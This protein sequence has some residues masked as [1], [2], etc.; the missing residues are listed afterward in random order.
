M[1]FYVHPDMQSEC[2]PE[3]MIAS[4]LPDDELTSPIDHWN[5]PRV[6][7]SGH[8]SA[9]VLADLVRRLGR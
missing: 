7:E 9:E 4:D 2:V 3:W 8:R 5:S 1:R 6:A